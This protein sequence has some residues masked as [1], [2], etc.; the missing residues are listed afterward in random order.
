MAYVLSFGL[1]LLELSALVQAKSGE[2]DEEGGGGEKLFFSDRTSRRSSDD[3]TGSTEGLDSLSPLAAQ[4]L[5]LLS[6]PCRCTHASILSASLRPCEISKIHTHDKKLT[7]LQDKGREADLGRRQHQ[8]PQAQH[9]RR[10]R[11]GGLCRRRRRDLRGE[12]WCLV[13]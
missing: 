8:D 11:P 1:S 6:W 3:A 9:R 10:A 2:H 4:P 12:L 5:S 7:L 13:A